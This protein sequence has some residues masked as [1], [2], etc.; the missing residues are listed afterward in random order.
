MLLGD[1]IGFTLCWIQQQYEPLKLPGDVYIINALP[2]EMHGFDFA[3]IMLLK[4]AA[5][6]YE[7]R[8]N[9]S[10]ARGPLGSFS[11]TGSSESREY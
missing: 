8:T 1:L 9:L 7:H 4:M 10:T 11:L 3:I 6:T 2:V 5:A